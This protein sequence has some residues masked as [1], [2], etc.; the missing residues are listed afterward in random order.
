[1]SHTKTIPVASN[2]LALCSVQSNLAADLTR[3][4]TLDLMSWCDCQQE[5]LWENMSL[6]EILNVYRATAEYETFEAWAEDDRKIAHAAWNRAVI[7]PGNR[8]VAL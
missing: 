1:M 2:V 8:M 7:D 6:Q 4:E 3:N 5:D